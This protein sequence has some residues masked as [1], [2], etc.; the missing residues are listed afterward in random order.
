MK[1]RIAVI[2]NLH[3]ASSAALFDA[4]CQCLQQ[5]GAQVQAVTRPGALPSSAAITEALAACE[6]AIAIGGDGTIV[7]VAKSAAAADRPVLGINGGHLGFLAGLEKDELEQLPRLL[8][9]DYTTDDR[10]LLEITVH[11]GETTHTYLAMN[12]AVISRG[13]LSRLL[14]TEVSAEGRELLSC[15]GDGIIIATPTGST[16]YSLS[17][18]GA[19][20]D[21]QVDCLLVTPVC[22]HSVHTRPMILPASARLTVRALASDEETAYL[23]VDGEEN[24]IIA[25]TDRLTVARADRTARL[26]RLK[27]ATFYDVLEQKMLGRRKP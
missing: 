6:L 22:P 14:D 4:V 12:E 10:L 8:E 19:V 25:S 1:M 15:C 20:V 2:P 18:G 16:A 23:T 13:G 9:G 26:I 11:Q 27:S 5:A 21:P 3:R 7:H 17:A 24:V